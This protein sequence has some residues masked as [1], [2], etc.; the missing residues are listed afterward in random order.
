M[1]V[2]RSQRL[3][4]AAIHVPSY[5][6]V[7]AARGD[8]QTF[9]VLQGYYVIVSNITGGAGG[10]VVKFMGDGA[11]LTFPVDSAPEAVAALRRLQKE[12]S[13]V[14]RRFDE[15]SHVQV[16]IGVGS[17]ICGDLGPPGDQRFDVVGDAV[18]QLF[19]TPWSDFAVDPEVAKLL[20]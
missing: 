13:A 1:T 17:V 4:L 11:L 2:P 5:T 10:R 7:C 12:A 14:W 18:N 9:D 8:A 20:E 3:I 15:D 6:R 16:K 19:K